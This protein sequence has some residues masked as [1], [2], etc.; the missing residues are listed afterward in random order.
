[1]KQALDV[2]ETVLN[3]AGITVAS[4]DLES[5]LSIILLI[6]SISSILI[7]GGYMAYKYFKNKKTDEGVKTIIDT[8][9]QAK[10]VIEKNKEDKK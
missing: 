10:D 7:R 9:D 6:I 5:V 8:L 2:G 1:M 3:I 4:Q